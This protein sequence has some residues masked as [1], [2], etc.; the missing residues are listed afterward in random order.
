MKSAVTVRAPEGCLVNP[1]YPAPVRA[2]MLSAYRCFDA[3]LKALAQAVPDKVIAGG[4]ASTHSTAISH[5]DGSR[6]KVY[7]E[8]F[9]GGYGASPRVDGCDAVDSTLSNCTNVPVEAM[10]LAFHHLQVEAY[11]LVPDSFGHGRPRG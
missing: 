10:D 3:V 7:L 5:L 6:Y 8:I 11:E 1:I 2:R 9:G 4:H